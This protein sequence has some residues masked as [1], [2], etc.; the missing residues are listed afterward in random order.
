M[1]F[2][3]CSPLFLMRSWFALLGTGCYFEKTNKKL[4]AT[5]L[6]KLSG[7]LFFRLSYKF[8]TT[9]KK[10]KKE[11]GSILT[12]DVKVKNWIKL[13]GSFSDDDLQLGTLTWSLWRNSL[14]LTRTPGPRALWANN[15][16]GL[17]YCVLFRDIFLHR[18]FMHCW[19]IPTSILS[20]CW[21]HVSCF[22]VLFF[23]H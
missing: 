8:E 13:H 7:L 21:H 4:L 16:W 9:G 23:E 19:W 15:S 3:S 20:Q 18:C 1:F 6:R 22:G 10:M 5:V 17:H 14:R 2:T 12:Q 11:T